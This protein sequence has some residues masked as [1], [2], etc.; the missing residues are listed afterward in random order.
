MINSEGKKLEI[1]LGRKMLEFLQI[2]S[3]D[4]ERKG[5]E[6][7]ELLEEDE[8][9]IIGTAL[10]TLYQ[11]ATCHRKCYK[12]PH[13][14]EAFCGRAFNLGSSAHLLTNLGFYDEAFGMI[15]SFSEISNLLSLSASDPEL[16]G[17]WMEA[18]VG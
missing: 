11:A 5:D 16:F 9:E 2:A 4:T 8:L 13:I 6:A 12:G 15:R 1:P 17:K 18:D 7:L 3:S 10:S 14:F